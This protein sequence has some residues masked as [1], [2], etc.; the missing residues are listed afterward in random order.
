M[1]LPIATLLETLH[2]DKAE[3]KRRL[4]I[5]YYVFAAIF[6]WEVFP[7]Y[8]F[9]LLTGI[10]VFCLADHH[11]LVFTNLF[12]GASGNEGLGFLSICLDW[13]CM[14]FESAILYPL[15]RVADSFTPDIAGLQS[16]LWYPLQTLVNCMIGII[17]CYILFMVW[18]SIDLVRRTPFS[19]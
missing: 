1:N 12:G 15:N 10:S 5:F 2:R 18:L 9:P 11:N 17:G 3:T 19:Y 14:F 6:V 4:R 16:P 13:N 7:E 8:I